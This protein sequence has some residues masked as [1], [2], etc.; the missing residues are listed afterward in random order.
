MCYLKEFHPNLGFQL[1]CKIYIA[2][3][4]SRGRQESLFKQGNLH[5]KLLKKRVAMQSDLFAA[6]KDGFVLD[7]SKPVTFYLSKTCARSAA[8]L[9]CVKCDVNLAIACGLC[10]ASCLPLLFSKYI[11]F[12]IFFFSFGLCQPQV[13]SC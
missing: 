5:F 2:I 3:N 1:N 9:E 6:R 12:E 7:Q 10:F 13:I 4:V 8:I 11:C